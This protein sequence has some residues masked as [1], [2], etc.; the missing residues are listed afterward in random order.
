MCNSDRF[1]TLLV[2]IILTC[3]NFFVTLLAGISRSVYTNQDS[4]SF[5]SEI[6]KTHN[7]ILFIASFDFTTLLTNIPVKETINIILDRLFSTWDHYQSFATEK[8]REMLNL[9][10][11]EN[12]FAFEDKLYI[13][14]T[15]HPL[16]VAF[17]LY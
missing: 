6:S 11:E 15:M 10:T 8:F 4:F 3:Q 14:L 9:C 13:K 1:W 2:R 5:A 16:G 12:L 7:N 17:P